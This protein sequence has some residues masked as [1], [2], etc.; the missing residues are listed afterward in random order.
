MNKAVILI[1]IT[2]SVF[3]CGSDH[4]SN[5]KAEKILEKCLK[6]DPIERSAII[7]TGENSFNTESKT[8]KLSKYERLQKDGYI[9]MIKIQKK[10]SSGNDALSQWR[11][12]FKKFNIQV[13]EKAKD[14][15]LETSQKG[16]IVRVKMFNYE[17]DEVLEVQ[18][19]LANNSA[20][21][22]VQYI[23]EDITPFAILSSKDPSEFWI[24]DRRM[25]KTS[26]G[27]KYCDDY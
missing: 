3:S 22:K 9:E 7:Q 18:E 17:V 1:L 11:N 21:V 13:T 19:F 4:L 16:R 26:N 20:K 6:I 8:N 15:I 2:I 12:K 10:K 23:A 5:S 24:K 25:N 14:Y 27:W